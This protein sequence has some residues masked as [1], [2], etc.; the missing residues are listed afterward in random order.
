MATVS[1]EKSFQL[2]DLTSLE[3]L[4]K[5]L[6]TPRTTYVEKRDYIAE[7]K[8]GIALLKQRLSSLEK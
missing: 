2:S 6:N 7:N 4:V 1:F 3:E 8:Q 5:D